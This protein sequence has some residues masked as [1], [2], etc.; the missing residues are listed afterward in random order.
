MDMMCSDGLPRD[1]MVVALAPP[2]LP[3]EGL[4]FPEAVWGPIVDGV[5]TVLEH[6]EEKAEST[7][8]IDRSNI[9]DFNTSDSVRGGSIIIG[10]WEPER[11]SVGLR[12]QKTCVCV[13]R[14][15]VPRHGGTCGSRVGVNLV[16]RLHWQR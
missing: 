10:L 14:G 6:I 4:G 12:E 5:V 2:L 13:L 7:F 3:V 11:V 1:E 16:V 9:T 8:G 15:A